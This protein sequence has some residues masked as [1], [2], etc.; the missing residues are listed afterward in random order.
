MTPAKPS[1]R[2]FL[3]GGAFFVALSA[4][5]VASAV[6]ASASPLVW[7]NAQAWVA[8][9][10][11]VTGY[12][13]AIIFGG[14]LEDENGSEA[15]FGSLA[16]YTEV[17]GESRTLVDDRS[18]ATSQAQ[19]DRAR[20]RIGVADLVELGMIDRPEGMEP[21]SAEPTEEATPE[22]ER[23]QADRD[24][25]GEHDEERFEAGAEE[26][27]EERERQQAD[28]PTPQA[29]FQEPSSSPSASP[30]S[31]DVVVLGEGDSENVS[32]DGNMVEFTIG[33][34]RG[35]ATAGY[36]GR[37]EASLEY[38]ELTAFG[39]PVPDFEDEY[40]VEEALEV[41]DSDGVTV[42]EVPVGIRF[43][44]QESTFEDDQEDWEGQGVRAALTVWVQVGDPEDGN[45]FTIDFANVW[46]V[47]STHA[48]GAGEG[49]GGGER[50]EAEQ[51][52]IPASSGRL[53]TTGGSI[54]ALVTAAVVAVGG[55]VTATL[56]A[57]KRT[58]AMDDRIED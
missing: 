24:G 7:A 2:R 51:K 54:A 56:L 21:S 5:G 32:T 50:G 15:L 37:T 42:D 35:E 13:T 46:A 45:G 25:R 9:G 19:V 10:D 3:A 41:F 52:P 23:T 12:S 17:R 33:D 38:G 53:A 26:A 20:V 39:V 40:V 27:P 18:G 36:D 14:E 48:V 34:V 28:E 31:E 47:G 49:S 29:P 8:D 4:L 58:T 1:A 55:G 44:V 6:P 11:L 16:P 57:R 30:S 22:P 43:L